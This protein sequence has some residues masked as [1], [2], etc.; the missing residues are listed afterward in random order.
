MV[1]VVE[2]WVVASIFRWWSP[3]VITRRG[4]VERKITWG[5]SVWML[6]ITIITMMVVSMLTRGSVQWFHKGRK[7]F[8]GGIEK[9]GCENAGERS[10]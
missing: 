1:V 7:W 4:V 10:T 3:A 2:G 5:R 8:L 9:N 6:I